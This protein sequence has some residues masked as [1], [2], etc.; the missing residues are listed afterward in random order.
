MTTTRMRVDATGTPH[1]FLTCEGYVMAGRIKGSKKCSQCGWIHHPDA[2]CKPPKQP[3]SHADGLAQ[4][5][6]INVKHI[7]EA[8]REEVP[9]AAIPA[10]VGMTRAAVDARM[11]MNRID[12]LEA[13]MSMLEAKMNQI[14]DQ[15]QAVL[16]DIA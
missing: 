10:T 2:G 12:Y 4:I 14:A 7:G 13:R 16:K 9:T 5:A 8:S 15:I 11:M 6:A 1:Q 3:K